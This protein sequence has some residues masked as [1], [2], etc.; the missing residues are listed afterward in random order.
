MASG[1]PDPFERL[2]ARCGLKMSTADLHVVPRDVLAAPGD[3]G[4]HTLVTVSGAQSASE[5]LR[6]LFLTEEEDARP[7]SIRDVLW[8]L[9][10]DSWA[11]ENADRDFAHWITL[12]NYP[13]DD[14]AAARLFEL[15]VKQASALIALLGE[16]TYKELL[17]VYQAE[18]AGSA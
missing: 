3:L 18:V 2:A 10:S 16:P 9:S 5:S 17:A 7:I 1:R 12:Y 8:W 11:V 14:R 15:H 4:R 6:I 13:D